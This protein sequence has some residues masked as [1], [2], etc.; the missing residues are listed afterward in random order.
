MYP[1]DQPLFEMWLMMVGGLPAS[2]L[3][4]S[5]ALIDLAHHTGERQYIHLSVISQQHHWLSFST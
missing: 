5:T 3:V 1:S 2:L 4:F